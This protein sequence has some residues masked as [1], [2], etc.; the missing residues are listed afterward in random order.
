MNIKKNR[1]IKFRN[2]KLFN[3]LRV[4]SILKCLYQK[5]KLLLLNKL[6]NYVKVMQLPKAYKFKISDLQVLNTFNKDLKLTNTSTSLQH[7]GEKK[8]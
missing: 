4:I 3:N 1:I 6:N 5:I 8:N 7:E 2:F